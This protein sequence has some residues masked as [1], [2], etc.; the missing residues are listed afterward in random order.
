MK[1]YLYKWTKL[2][3]RFTFLTFSR[4]YSAIETDI[5]TAES[6]AKI[7]VLHTDYRAKILH[8]PE[9]LFKFQIARLCNCK[10]TDFDLRSWRSILPLIVNSLE[11]LSYSEMW[12]I[13]NPQKSPLKW[14]TPPMLRTLNK[15][16]LKVEKTS[17]APWQR[18]IAPP[19]DVMPTPSMPPPSAPTVFPAHPTLSAPSASTGPSTSST[20]EFK[21]EARYERQISKTSTTTDSTSVRNSIQDLGFENDIF[22]SDAS[23][24][25]LFSQI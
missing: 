9:K 10:E 1:P 15:W 7:I 24:D 21:A 11:P 3:A 2:K 14:L 23:D 6:I 13:K 19:R 12:R 4:Q 25:E 16:P 18:C 5:G 22:I 17:T 20:R 8:I